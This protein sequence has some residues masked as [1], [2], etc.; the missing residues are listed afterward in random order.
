MG[1]TGLSAAWRVAYVRY[2]VS[3]RI[4]DKREPKF[5]DN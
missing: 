4:A 3:P 1:L 2:D 5:T